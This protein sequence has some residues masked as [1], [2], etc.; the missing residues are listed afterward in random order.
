VAN[1]GLDFL[2]KSFEFIRDDQTYSL[3][4]GM[5]KFKEGTFETGCI[6][7]K[8]P[9]T[10]RVLEV[11]YNGKVLQ[12]EALKT[13]IDKWVRAGVIELSCGASLQQVVD[14]NEW[15]DLSDKYFVL[16]GA[17]SA[18]GPLPLLL[19]LGANV[20]GIDLDRN[21]IWVSWIHVW[22]LF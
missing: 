6:K 9:Q 13:Q 22:R 8:L 21:F 18:M 15:L 2:H 16:L 12:G 3:A 5:A 4:Q 19:A 1:A 17:S 20:I 14:T 10:K 7:G 11:P